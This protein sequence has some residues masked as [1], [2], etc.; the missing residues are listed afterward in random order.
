MGAA[1]MFAAGT[2]PLE[3]ARR[4]EVSDKSAYQWHRAWKTGG[5]EALVSKGPSGPDSLLDE[6]QRQELERSLE[7]GPETAGLGGDQRWTLCGCAS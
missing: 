7:A 1:A 4:F 6:A 2:R 3:V 5:A